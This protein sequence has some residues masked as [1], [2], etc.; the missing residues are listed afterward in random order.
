M[1]VCCKCMYMSLCSCLHL[2]VSVCACICVG[3]RVGLEVLLGPP[4]WTMAL[5]FCQNI[6]LDCA[7]QQLHTQ[8]Q[9]LRGNTHTEG[10][11]HSFAKSLGVFTGGQFSLTLDTCVYVC[12]RFSFFCVFWC[13]YVVSKVIWPTAS[14]S[15]ECDCGG[16]LHFWFEGAGQRK[17]NLWKPL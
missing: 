14:D 5:L 15:V 3:V 2:S 13:V 9:S 16:W 6:W 17:Q 7:S 10:F 12:L 1:C 11:T 4:W 8:T